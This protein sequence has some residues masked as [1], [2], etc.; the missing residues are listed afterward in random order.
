MSAADFRAAIIPKVQGGQ[1]L[2][3]AFQGLNLDFFVMTSSISATL[4]DPG[5]CDYSAANSFLDSLAQQR[6]L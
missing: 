2:D 3:R 4:G 1:S 6:N 5:Q